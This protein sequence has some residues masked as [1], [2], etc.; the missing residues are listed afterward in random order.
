MVLFFEEM[1]L[2]LYPKYGWENI[3]KT[4]EKLKIVKKDRK[5]DE[6]KARKLKEKVERQKRVVRAK[7]EGA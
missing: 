6:A 4:K 5:E 2:Y 3:E 1:L 7:E